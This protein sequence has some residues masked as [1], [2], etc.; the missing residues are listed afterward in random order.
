MLGAR[1]ASI[2]SSREEAVMASRRRMGMIMAVL[3]GRVGSVVA[4]L[5]TLHH[6]MVVVMF[7]RPL[8]MMVLGV[9]LSAQGQRHHGSQ[10]EGRD[11]ENYRFP[12]SIMTHG[13]CPFI[14]ESGQL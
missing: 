12:G 3:S 13:H 10:R 2:L 6:R 1:A 7:F 5:V 11:G 4:V 9:I 14:A 8:V